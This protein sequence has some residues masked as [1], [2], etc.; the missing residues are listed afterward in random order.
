MGLWEAVGA[1]TQGSTGSYCGEHCGAAAGGESHWGFS[2]EEWPFLLIGP[3]L[4]SWGS[5]ALHCTFL[6]FKLMIWH[7]GTELR[8]V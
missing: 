7:P 1:G 3:K 8:S 6:L 2:I 5:T 4:R